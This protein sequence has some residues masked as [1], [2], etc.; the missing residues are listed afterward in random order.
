MIALHHPEYLSVAS[1]PAGQV[2]AIGATA[3]E[4]GVFGNFYK[5]PARSG[6]RAQAT[7][8]HRS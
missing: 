8:P 6:R 5:H 1:Y 4:W 3:G 7:G 2:A